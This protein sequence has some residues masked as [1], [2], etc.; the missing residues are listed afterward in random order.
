LDNPYK[1]LHEVWDTV[2]FK[3]YKTVSL[4]LDEEAW[5]QLGTQAQ[6]FVEKYKFG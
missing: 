3:Y 2:M 1:N 6:Y 5:E 4:P